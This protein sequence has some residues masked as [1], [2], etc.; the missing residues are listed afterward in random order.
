[1]VGMLGGGLGWL[2]EGFPWFLV[3]G[4]RLAGWR[5]S[6]PVQQIVDRALQ[7]AEEGVCHLELASEDGS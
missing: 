5:K 2:E 3:G 4:W 7:A 1:M 6:Y